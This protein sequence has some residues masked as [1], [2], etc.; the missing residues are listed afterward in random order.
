MA[1]PVTWRVGQHS[2]QATVGL[3][4]VSILISTQLAIL[5]SY[6]STDTHSEIGSSVLITYRSKRH[7]RRRI[8]D[9]TRSRRN[10]R[11]V[12]HMD[13]DMEH[14]FEESYTSSTGIQEHL[15]YENATDYDSDLR[16][17][18]QVRQMLVSLA[19]HRYFQANP[20]KKGKKC[21][22]KSG[23]FFRALRNYGCNCYPSNWDSIHLPTG[24]ILW[25]IGLNGLALDKADEC[26]KNAYHRYRCFQLDGCHVGDS[27]QYHMVNGEIICGPANNPNYA[28]NP[29]GNF[30]ALSGCE[31]EKVLAEGL[32][33]QI[34]NSP[35]TYKNKNAG[36]YNAWQRNGM[37]LTAQRATK[38]AA[39]VARGQETTC[40]GTYPRRR[41]YDSGQFEC[42]NDR[43]IR[44][45]GFC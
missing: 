10:K 14:G 15:T 12:L 18:G 42:C 2:S 34:G 7:H 8:R 41:A 17:F 44:P 30:C 24:N 43:K 27:Y 45:I 35:V 19:C 6:A 25:Q 31:I 22:Q 36:K 37:C 32:Y 29:E 26:C 28:S 40:C 3:N 33:A 11:S 39:A 13:L 16:S 21:P 23:H 20:N 38:P 1:A 9:H 5:G 4:S